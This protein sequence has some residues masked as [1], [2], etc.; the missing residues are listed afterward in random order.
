M[1]T[2]IETRPIMCHE[3]D[4]VIVELHYTIILIKSILACCKT[5]AEL[6]KMV[7]PKNLL[8]IIYL[9]GQKNQIMASLK[10]KLILFVLITIVQSC[11]IHDTVNR[12]TFVG[13][14]LA[15]SRNISDTLIIYR[16]YTFFH[17]Y[18]ELKNK[19]AFVQTGKWKTT[20]NG[21]YELTNWKADSISLSGA[22]I[23]PLRNRLTGLIKFSYPLVTSDDIDYVKFPFH[24]VDEPT[25][26]DKN[27]NQLV[28]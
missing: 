16:D 14:Y 2:I 6:I 28:F 4:L 12:N 15:S 10:N 1:T 20:A 3:D 8:S 19:S 24:K 17:V 22:D 18:H 11:Q 9:F 23:F 7:D 21:N 27:R 26:S 13:M 25:Y 5:E